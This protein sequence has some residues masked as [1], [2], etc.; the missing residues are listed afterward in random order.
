MIGYAPVRRETVTGDGAIVLGTAKSPLIAPLG[1]PLAELGPEGFLIRS[2]TI[3]GK[4]V[5]VIAANRMSACST[6]CSASSS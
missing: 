6:A 4:R 1:L 2:A 3:G 5:T